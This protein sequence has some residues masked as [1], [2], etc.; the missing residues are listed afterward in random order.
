MRSTRPA[1]WAVPLV[2]VSSLALAACGSNSSSNSSSASSS[3]GGLA[4]SGGGATYSIAFEG[5]LSGDNQQLGINEVNAT[6]V[7]IDQANASGNLGF[8]LKLVK[9]DDQGDRAQARAG[10]A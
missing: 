2:L 6:Q 10:A 5:P 8:K 1:M 9:A 3:G 4:G 7:A